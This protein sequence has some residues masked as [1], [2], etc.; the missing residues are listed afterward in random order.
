MHDV[1]DDALANSI[2][3]TQSFLRNVSFRMAK[4]Y[5]EHLF[6]G[7]FCHVRAFTHSEP[8]LADGILGVVSM[9]A[10]KQV[11]WPNASALIADVADEHSI[12]D[13]ADG[14]FIGDSVGHRASSAISDGAITVSTQMPCP[15]P[16]FRS[17]TNVCPEPVTDLHGLETSAILHRHG[18]ISPTVTTVGDNPHIELP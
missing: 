4:T 3:F 2:A 8:T 7:Q 18:S 12:R 11:F 15:V 9:C 5:F 10:K 6:A 17:F 13:W 14:E 1:T 16:A